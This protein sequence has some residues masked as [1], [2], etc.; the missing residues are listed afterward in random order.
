MIMIGDANKFI[1]AIKESRRQTILTDDYLNRQLNLGRIHHLYDLKM[2]EV[3]ALSPRSQADVLLSSVEEEQKEFRSPSPEKRRDD[4]SDDDA[5]S[6]S[7]SHSDRSEENYEEADADSK[8][9]NSSRSSSRRGSQSLSRNS[10]DVD[11]ED[12]A[13]GEENN[14]EVNN[15]MNKWSLNLLNTLDNE[16]QV[17]SDD[18]ND[19]SDS[20]DNSNNQEQTEGSCI[21]C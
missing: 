12:E 13:S 2:Q 21:T 1:T 11:D 20:V 7:D 16:A 8:A 18:E 15:L 4:A 19:Y 17:N 5:T 14:G 6:D 10:A 9:N 3:E